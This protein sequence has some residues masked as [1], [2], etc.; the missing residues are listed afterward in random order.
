MTPVVY[1]IALIVAI[2][3][4]LLLTL[5]LKMNSFMALFFTA[6]ALAVFFGS[7]VMDGLNAITG[8]FGNSRKY[9]SARTL[10]RHS[11]HGRSGFRGGSGYQQLFCKTV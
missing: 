1:M 5:K 8:A 9:R 3:I 2:G 10:W 4:L 6:L 11:C 7:S